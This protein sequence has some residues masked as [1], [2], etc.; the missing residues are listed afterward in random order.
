MNETKKLNNK[1]FCPKSSNVL[2][3]IN[4]HAQARIVQNGLNII[5]STKVTKLNSIIASAMINTQVFFC[6]K[7]A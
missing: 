6:P 3:L 4:Q 7:L 1:H 5:H 2:T